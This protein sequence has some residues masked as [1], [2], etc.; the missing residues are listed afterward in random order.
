MQNSATNYSVRAKIF[1]LSGVLIFIMVAS[2]GYI[3]FEIRKSIRYVEAQ[4]NSSEAALAINN[5]RTQFLVI[6]YWF[7]EFALSWLF[8]SQTKAQEE[9]AKFDDVLLQLEKL[10]SE[11]AK[12]LKVE[13]D[14]FSKLMITAAENYVDGNR[15]SGTKVNAEAREINVKLSQQLSDRFAKFNAESAAS[16]DKVISQ[17]VYLSI[18]SLVSIITG[19]ILSVIISSLVATNLSR[20]LRRVTEGIAQSGDKVESA[21]QKMK[22]VSGALSESANTTA[23]FLEEASASIE[24]LTVIVGENEKSLKQASILS[25]ASFKSAEDGE[26]QIRELMLSMVEISD[27][28]K[29]I[30]GII[31]VIDDI[32]SQTN[33]LALNAAVEAA[34]AG[35]QG[36]GFAVVADAVQ[37]LA[38]RSA[39]AASEITTLIKDSVKKIDRGSAIAANGKTALQSIVLSAKTVADLNENIASTSHEQSIG[40]AKINET[41]NKVDSLS[42][43]NAKEA[44]FVAGSSD[45]LTNE[46]F[47]LQLSVNKMK[48]IIE[49]HSNADMRTIEIDQITDA[50]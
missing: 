37:L 22:I 29:K 20:Q 33:L 8:E 35:E 16:A 49:G 50:V 5:V 41:V 43:S 40:I 42:Q 34:R 44:K 12:T 23:Q 1:G 2:L 17:S 26:K 13:G 14:Q 4:K 32:A 48:I 31:N 47:S 46:A 21:S 3:T 38:Q 10:D 18:I 27:S 6:Q 19:F 45:E 28:A 25:L 36:K 39:Q 15:I 9:K 24:E 30:V 11:F 7:N